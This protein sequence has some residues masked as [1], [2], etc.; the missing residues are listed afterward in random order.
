MDFRVLGPVEAHKDGA[1][2]A[3][4]GSKVHTVLATLLLARGR[5]V[6]DARLNTLLWGWEPPATSG[7]QIYTYMSRLRKLLGDEVRIERRQPGYLLQ[8]PHSRFDL[9]EFERLDKQGREAL[10]RKRFGEAGALLTEALEHWRGTAL[11]N[12][13]EH[14][15][16]A[17][18]PQLE[19]A[20]MHA[21]ESR[22]EADLALGRHE[23][24]A[25]ELTGLVAQ[26]PLRE[27]LRAQLMTAYY[28]SGR[29]SDALQSYYEGR[30][31]L[32]DQLGIDPGE[33]LGSTYEAVLAGNRGPGPGSRIRQPEPYDYEDED[34]PAMLPPDTEEFIGRQAELAALR[35]QLADSATGRGPRHLLV[36]GMAGVGKT[37]LALH[38]AHTSAARYPGGCLFAEIAQPDGRPRPPAEVLTTLLRGLGEH[39]G[40]GGAG[41]GADGPVELDELVRLYRARTAGRRL[42]VVL[43]GAVSSRGL[44][45]VLSGSPD[46]VVLITSRTRLTQVTGARTTALAPFGDAAAFDLL[47]ASAGRA[48][49]LAEPDATDDVLAYCAGLPLALRITGSRLAA[50]PYWPVAR[51]AERLADPQTRLRELSFGGTG[52]TG[53][54]MQALRQLPGSDGA[55]TTL[56]RLAGIGVDSF[57]AQR[58]AM[59]LGTRESAAEQRLE[60]LVDGA[61]LDICGVDRQ[62]RPLYRFHELVLLL[63]GL[64]KDPA[65]CGQPETTAAR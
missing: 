1:R 24:L 12:V 60:Q 10:R 8:A 62:G 38:A 13:T 42:L 36:T 50:R 63:A 19:E 32:A 22:I 16:D 65:H 11:S 40:R 48:R 46:A 51:L 64:L 58:A 55:R 29:Q 9:L 61:L 7:A 4:S 49:L 14:L 2:V 47:A 23:Q 5:V 53:A 28:R 41:G 27:K 34:V 52:V 3:L 17:E 30:S 35:A 20:R 59:Y 18:L 21:L 43:D 39:V 37:A 26:F 54:L 33:A 31:L 44:D 25:A 45:P 56:I 6:S 57:P 15:A